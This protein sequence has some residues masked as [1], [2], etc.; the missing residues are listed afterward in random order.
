MIKM[1]VQLMYSKIN[2]WLILVNKVAAGQSHWA[3]S[4]GQVTWVGSWDWSLWSGH[5]VGSLGWITVTGSGHLIGSLGQVWAGSLG[6]VVGHAVSDPGGS[7]F[8][9]NCSFFE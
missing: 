6:R 7:S 5:W 9:V 1:A 2:T 4:M 8:T 3:G